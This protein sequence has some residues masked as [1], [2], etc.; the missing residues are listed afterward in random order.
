MRTWT[1]APY[2][3]ICA[4]PCRG[5]IYQGQPMLVLTSP[6]W[7]GGKIRCMHCAGEP[8]PRDL[9]PL[10]RKTKPL[11]PTPLVR[12]GTV[13]LPFDFKVAAAGREPGEDL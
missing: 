2:E 8:V 4:G 11:E 7:T 5:P 1:R 10:E 9:P 6:A 3:R 12:A 13:K